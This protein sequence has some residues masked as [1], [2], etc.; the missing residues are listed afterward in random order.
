M[1]E[2]IF[3]DNYDP[4]ASMFG[5]TSGREHNGNLNGAL[6]YEDYIKIFDKVKNVDQISVRYLIKKDDLKINKDKLDNLH[7][8]TD[9]YF[10]DHEKCIG[11][12]KNVLIENNL[13]SWCEGEL[14]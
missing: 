13:F 12:A 11:V 1:N 9:I 14:E 7:I 4:N 2:N 3:F 8:K 10:F 5:I 6:S